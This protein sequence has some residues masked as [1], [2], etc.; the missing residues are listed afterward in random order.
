[1]YELVFRY[2]H[3]LAERHNL[4]HAT[5]QNESGQTCAF[6]QQSTANS[7]DI[8]DIDTSCF[9]MFF[10]ICFRIRNCSRLESRQI[11]AGGQPWSTM[12][13]FDDLCRYVFL[14]KCRSS[15]VGEQP[16]KGRPDLFCQKV[17][18]LFHAERLI[19]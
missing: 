1:M 5:R 6:H 9:S 7:G 16:Q 13:I 17:S 3:S 12:V 10:H 14:S 11:V 4:V 19:V 15:Q 18:M 2:A 8:V